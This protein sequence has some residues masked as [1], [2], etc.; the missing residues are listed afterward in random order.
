MTKK[1]NNVFCS[2]DTLVPIEKVLPNP[3]NPNVH[4]NTQ[5]ELLA[6]IIKEQGWRSSIT[7]SNRSGFVVRGHGRLLAAK[8]IGLKKVPVDFQ[9][10]ESDASEKADLIADNKIAEL[11]EMDEGLLRGLL[12]DI[13]FEDFDLSLTAIE[14]KEVETLL[15]A[16]PELNRRIESLEPAKMK[17]ILISVPVEKYEDLK[18]EMMKMK[19]IRGLTLDE[20][21][22]GK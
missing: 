6:K 21:K 10:Y 18:F 1:I 3:N 2:H 20:S 19:T 4:P 9:D 16:E 13:H 7:V 15:K 17:Y 5:I 11:A 22:D 8:R 14:E 12:D